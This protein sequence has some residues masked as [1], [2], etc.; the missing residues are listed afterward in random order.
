MPPLATLRHTVDNRDIRPTDVNISDNVDDSF[1]T[2]TTCLTCLPNHYH[3][4]LFG[5][6]ERKFTMKVW[7]QLRVVAR[8]EWK[9]YLGLGKT[10]KDKHVHARGAS[11]L[12]HRNR[13]EAVQLGVHT[14]WAPI[15]MDSMHLFTGERTIPRSTST[16]PE[17]S[18]R[19]IQ[20]LGS[21]HQRRVR[22]LDFFLFDPRSVPHTFE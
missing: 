14:R 6:G 19:E 3:C 20:T 2:L 5:M 15:K 8:T 22:I 16:I 12:N 11:S 9:E 18:K 10:W 4:M 17:R 7:T 21:L 1:L 13:S